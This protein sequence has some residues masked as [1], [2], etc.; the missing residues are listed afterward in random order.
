M[1]TFIIIE[2]VVSELGALLPKR[3]IV[4]TLTL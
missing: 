3:F 2:H 1:S 4:S